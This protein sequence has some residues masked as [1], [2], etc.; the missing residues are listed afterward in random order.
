[1]WR[2]FIMMEGIEKQ[3]FEIQPSKDLGWR[4]KTRDRFRSQRANIQVLAA[5]PLGSGDVKAGGMVFVQMNDLD[6][7]G[8]KPPASWC[9]HG[10]VLNEDEQN[11]SASDRIENNQVRITFMRKSHMDA[12][13]GIQ[14]AIAKCGADP[15][16]L[17][18]VYDQFKGALEDTAKSF[19]IKMVVQFIPS[20]RGIIK[21][22]S[23]RTSGMNC[24]NGDKVER[25]DAREIET[26]L[27]RPMMFEMDGTYTRDKEG[28]RITAYFNERDKLPHK[29]FDGENHPIEQHARCTVHLSN[30]PPEVRIYRI[31][32]GAPP[33]DITDKEEKVLVGERIKLQGEVVGTGLGEEILKSWKM[34]GQIIKDWR[35]SL[36]EANI[37]EFDDEDLGGG[38][39]QWTW[40]DGSFGGTARTVKYMADYSGAKLEGKTRF[41]VFE[42]R[43]E[44]MKKELGGYVGIRP[45]GGCELAPESPAIR[46]EARVTLPDEKADA[47]N[48]IQFVQLTSS[49]GWFLRRHRPGFIWYSMFVED[50][51]DTSYPYKGP[52]CGGKTAVLEMIDSPG[53]PLDAMNAAYDDNRFRTYLMFRPGTDDRKTVWVPLKRIDWGWKGAVTH[54]GT[55]YDD[56]QPQCAERYRLTCE[57]P[58]SGYDPSET[59]SPPHPVW[60][61]H[62][63]EKN[64]RPVE[65][66][67]LYTTDPHEH[68]P[69][70]GDY[71]GWQCN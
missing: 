23:K 48:C 51:L 50:H 31:T 33:K 61:A 70:H 12:A 18:K 37:V 38:I 46:L 67:D 26:V 24:K 43:V 59:D 57:K 5:G 69:S 20:C 47:S 32:E 41:R 39:V 53:D 40:V 16:C 1:M 11:A 65:M 36:K 4:H 28:D 60:S 56:P 21:T 49:R 22:T 34:P 44:W 45:V 10:W 9:T 17:A 30:G 6:V 35:A 25:D 8:V 19:P 55:I 64:M 27:C 15:E 54:T 71:P 3:A 68:P 58:P 63:S 13:K 62:S 42:P 66:V 2:G 29:A 14:Q 52:A 7:F